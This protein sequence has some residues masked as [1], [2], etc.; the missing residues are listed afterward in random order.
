M[1]N[2]NIFKIETA[3]KSDD[4]IV[5]KAQAGDNDAQEFI[6]KK[7]KNLVKS[8]ARQYHINGADK[9]DLI[10]EGMI[11][12]YKAIRDYNHEKNIYFHVFAQL[13]ITRQ[14]LTAVRGANRKKHIP[15]NDYVSLNATYEEDQENLIDQLNKQ[16]IKGPEEILIEK[17]DN[18]N[19]RKTLK[20][21]LTEKE[22]RIVDLY[23]QGYSYVE[24]AK[25]IGISDKG[26]SSALHRVKKKLTQKQS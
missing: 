23:L 2:T 22:V 13:C 21:I 7:Y 25:I 1:E 18:E 11:G 12:L 14:I 9:E 19:L 17:E 8:N 24:M 3:S 4:E 10:Q 6:L 26:I 20:E 5:M 16:K 15:L